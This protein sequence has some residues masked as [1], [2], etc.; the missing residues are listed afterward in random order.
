MQRASARPNLAIFGS[1]RATNFASWPYTARPPAYREYLSREPLVVPEAQDAIGRI[2][3]HRQVVQIDDISE[4]R[5]TAAECVSQ[6]SEIAKAPHFGRGADAQGQRVGRRHRHLSPGSAAVHRQAD[7]AGAELCRPSGHRH[8]EHAAA[9]RAAPAHHRPHRALEQQTAT[10]EVLRSSVKFAR[11]TSAGVC[12]IL[13]NAVTNLRRQVRHVS[14]CWEEDA[15]ASL[16][17]TI[18]QPPIRG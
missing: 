18:R 9:E 16:Q 13:E 12:T 4:A 1:A 17:C 14:I 11:R 7:R 15:F 8:R 5:P 2:V 3:S 6:Q 10:S